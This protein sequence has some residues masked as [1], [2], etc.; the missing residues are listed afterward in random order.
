MKYV[1]LVLCTALIVVGT[2]NLVTKVSAVAP[3][4]KTMLIP[5]ASSA[6]VTVADCSG[7]C[8]TC[9][10]VVDVTVEADVAAT[11]DDGEARRG[12]P[13]RTVIRARPARRVLGLVGRLFCRRR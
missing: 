5:P 8:S 7:D 4:E 13:V 6:G 3:V 10:Y 11:A 12:G 1:L 2:D 9:P